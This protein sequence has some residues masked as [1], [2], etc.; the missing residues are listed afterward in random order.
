MKVARAYFFKTSFI[1]CL[2]L[3]L[4]I[5]TP[6]YGQSDSVALNNVYWFVTAIVILS[7]FLIVM[8]YALQQVLKRKK[9]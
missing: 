9:P 7:V 2:V 5:L 6:L 1:L 4:F 8:R 3:W